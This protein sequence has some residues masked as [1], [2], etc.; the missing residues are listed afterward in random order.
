M[1]VSDKVIHFCTT[2]INLLE[3]LT[4]ITSLED[5]IN[6]LKQEQA[7]ISRHIKLLETERDD[8]KSR[9]NLEKSK[10]ESE[11]DWT[12]EAFQWAIKAQEILEK[13]FGLK[14]FRP[15]QLAAINATL[16]KKDVLLLMPTGVC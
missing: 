7:K 6:N 8:L 12:G 13:R 1:T 9:Y 2:Y 16:S 3:I 5:K 14:E 15:K 11:R 10:R 4:K